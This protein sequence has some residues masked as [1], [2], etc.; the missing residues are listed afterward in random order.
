MFEFGVSV[1]PVVIAQVNVDLGVGVVAFK[2][3]IKAYG[4]S[5]KLYECGARAGFGTEVVMFCRGVNVLGGD[6]GH[7]GGDAVGHSIVLS[8]QQYVTLYALGRSEGAGC[9]N[10]P[11]FW[12]SVPSTTK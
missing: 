9:R 10:V 11:A 5:R 2:V 7:H 8:L 12:S 3:M 6:A 1:D 4:E